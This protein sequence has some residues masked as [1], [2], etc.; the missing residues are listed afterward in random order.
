MAPESGPLRWASD[1]TPVEQEPS[2]VFGGPFGQSVTSA[3][4]R[5]RV[6]YVERGTKALLLDGPEL[7]RELDRSYYH[8]ADYD[9][10]VAVGR[11]ADGREVVVHCP[12]RYDTLHVDDLWSGERLTGGEREPIDVFHSRL[13][14]SPDGNHLLAVGWVWQPYGVALAFSLPRA[15]ADPGTL[16][17]FGVVPFHRAVGAEGANACWLDADRIVVTTSA[18]DEDDA[19]DD[20]L[21]RAQVGVWSIGAGAWLHR[22]ALGFEAG[23]IVPRGEQVV[24]LHGHPRLVDVVSGRVVAEWPE[25]G[26]GRWTGCY[27]VS[28]LPSPVVAL[29][30]DGTR[31]AVAGADTITVIDLPER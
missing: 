14:V 22:S 18:D 30:P 28:H 19:D 2:R 29:R 31:L 3:D 21:G 4:G 17:G 27:G 9:Y 23:V 16:D 10:P 13:S 1:G 12:T 24:A 11:M 20:Q 8:A 26:T 5:Y 7:V 15:V 6:L 25:V